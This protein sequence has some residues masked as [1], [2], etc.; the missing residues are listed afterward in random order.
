MHLGIEEADQQL[1]DKL[2]LQRDA[3]VLVAERFGETT[4]AHVEMHIMMFVQPFAKGDDHVQEHFVAV[5]DDEGA[6]QRPSS[7]R[8]PINPSAVVSSASAQAIRSGS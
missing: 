5:G 3:A 8:A 4:F 7:R 6:A 1:P 2:A